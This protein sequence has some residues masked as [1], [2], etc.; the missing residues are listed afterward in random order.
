LDQVI[1]LTN[2]LKGKK[3]TKIYKVEHIPTGKYYAL[4]EIEAKSLD[5]LNEYKVVECSYFIGR[6]SSTF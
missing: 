4:K 1:S 6:S 3:N 5:K 2:P